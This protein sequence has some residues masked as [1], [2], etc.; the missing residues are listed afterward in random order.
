V[1]EHAFHTLS[2][3]IG[4]SYNQS[5]NEGLNDPHHNCNGT[6]TY[7]FNRSCNERSMACIFRELKCLPE[8]K[9]KNTED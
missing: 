2:V 5:A 8:R 7:F 6:Q 4:M 3:I 1:C 9:Q